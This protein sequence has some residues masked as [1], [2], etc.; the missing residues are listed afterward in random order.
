MNKIIT[1]LFTGNFELS[2]Q[3][4]HFEKGDTIAA[5]EKDAQRLVEGLC[6]EYY[7]DKPKKVK[8]DNKNHK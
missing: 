2:G 6:A 3:M 1:F 4:F 7:T 5:D 8:N